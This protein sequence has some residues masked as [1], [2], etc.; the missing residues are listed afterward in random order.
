M[1][2]SLRPGVRQDDSPCR[3]G[4]GQIGA[5]VAH[6]RERPAK[7]GP[8]DDVQDA[9]PGV[10]A[11]KYRLSGLLIDTDD[12]LVTF[13]KPCAIQK[14]RLRFMKS[15]TSVAIVDIHRP[16]TAR[17]RPRV[18]N[19]LRVARVPVELEVDFVAGGRKDVHEVLSAPDNLAERRVAGVPGL[20]DE[21]S[22]GGALSSLRPLCT[23]GAVGAAGALTSL[24][25]LRP[26]R[27]G[28]TARAGDTLG[29]LSAVC[30]SGALGTLGSLRARYS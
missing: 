11:E 24:R 21:P 7:V 9:G 30:T 22:A 13:A 17:R 6:Q 19:L 4:G 5:G 29:S 14:S 25:S 2:G 18:V 28:R 27:A 1:V 12:V 23:V 10:L 3:D 26:G 20:Q 8:L 15:P 16:T